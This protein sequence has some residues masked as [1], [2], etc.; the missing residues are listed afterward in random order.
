MSPTTRALVAQLPTRPPAPASAA[1]VDLVRCIGEQREVGA[2]AHLALLLPAQDALAE[3]VA[4]AIAQTLVALPIHGYPE[5]ETLRQL[6]WS[7][8]EPHAWPTLA[9]QAV[10]RL[11]TLRDGW[12]ALAMASLHRTGFV[13]EAA[14]RALGERLADD[15]A[16]IPLL[17]LRLNDWVPE[18]RRAA[19]AALAARIEVRYA[20]ALWRAWP[21]VGRL[22]EQRRADHGRIIR[23]I[24]MLLRT[25]EARPALTRAL[26]SPDRRVRRPAAQVALDGEAVDARLVERLLDDEDGIVR[27]L[28]A[29]QLARLSGSARVAAQT[30]ALEDL[31]AAVRRTALDTLEGDAATQQ[32]LLT[33][34][35]GDCQR[36]LRE[37]ARGR[38][39]A[40]VGHFDFAAHYRRL[41]AAPANTP[42]LLA[43]LAGLGECGVEDDVV[44]LD[45]FVADGRAKVRGVAL[46]ALAALDGDSV[47]FLVDALVDPS[48][49][50]AR[51]AARVLQRRSRKGLHELLVAVVESNVAPPH[52]RGFALAVICSATPWTRLAW[53]LELMR[54]ANPDVVTLA[55]LR[56]RPRTSVEPLPAER[57]AIEDALVHAPLT[58]DE[59]ARIRRQLDF[60]T[61]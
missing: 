52:A 33:A 57:V 43:A 20:D 51:S 7:E 17:L 16:E 32:R 45:P 58:A 40:L 41:L 30:R 28:G 11:A 31:S 37:L 12:A 56:L 1:L 49:R 8:G 21:L 4:T 48:R 2:L 54:S 13:R 3:A 50:V 5:L 46:Q 27:L 39:Q 60:W 29:Q 44:A 15:G 36:N 26:A 35:L 24:E 10:P 38:L 23:W 14:V 22:R 42:G 47:G 25:P 59:H 55:R 19:M 34:R 53:L 18:V 61:R 9:P 6:A